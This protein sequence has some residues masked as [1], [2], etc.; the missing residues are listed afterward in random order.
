M[1]TKV[2]KIDSF[3]ASNLSQTKEENKNKVGIAYNAYHQNQG[4][5]ECN[6]GTDS[7]F[8]DDSKE[9]KV[10][11]SFSEHKSFEQNKSE[12]EFEQE[13]KEKKHK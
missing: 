12:K 6:S 7:L 2:A 8:G 11:D 13:E 4:S 5:G 10:E 9:Q 1:E 3:V